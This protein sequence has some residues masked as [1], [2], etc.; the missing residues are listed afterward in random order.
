MKIDSNLNVGGLH[1]AAQQTPA[2]QARNERAGQTGRG[3]DSSHV[4]NLARQIA[5]ARRAADTLPDV[6][7][8]RVEQARARL[9]S[10]YYDSDEVK[11]AVASRLIDRVRESS[12]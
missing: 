6:R 11:N 2:E 3:S 1:K 10:G 12:G 8:D 9:A 4:S 7:A 5:E